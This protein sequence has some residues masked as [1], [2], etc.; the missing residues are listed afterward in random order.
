MSIEMLHGLSA[1]ALDPDALGAQPVVLGGITN[2][3]VQGQPQVTC[4]ATTGSAWPEFV[5]TVAV[6][7]IANFQTYSLATLGAAL[8]L[9]GLSMYT[10]N[11]DGC[12]FYG[13]QRQ[14]GG[15]NK[16][17]SNHM[18]FRA[19]DGIIYF[20]K[21]ACDHQ[22]NVVSTVNMI[23][24]SANGTTDPLVMLETQPL[25]TIAQ[26][27]QRFTLGPVTLQYASN[28]AV[29]LKQN[30]NFSL[31]LGVKAVVQ[32]SDSDLYPSFVYLQFMPVLTFTTSDVRLLKS[33]GIP[34]NGAQI[35]YV[36]SRIYLR[37][38]SSLTS[39]KFVAD[40]TAE[41]IEI[42]PREGM[43]AHE[44][45]FSC[46]QDGDASATVSI[47]LVGDRTNFPLSWDLTATLPS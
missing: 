2:G 30:S 4:E 13:V 9:Q 17:G 26:D 20:S 8:G 29:V 6:N 40:D 38:R 42:T 27:N 1:L 14:H 23:P 32:G 12:F 19:L 36:G 35:N 18:A 22:G 11:N 39:T 44:N 43:A 15:V 3:D 10:N 5:A 7:P 45:I 28:T 24:T 25:P 33:A 46:Q 21:F 16:S 34:L 41:H 37:K 47:K 31:D